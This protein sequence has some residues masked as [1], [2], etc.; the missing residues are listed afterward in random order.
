MATSAASVGEGAGDAPAPSARE[1][2]R[3]DIRIVEVVVA[4][5]RHLVEADRSP[6]SMSPFLRLT[7]CGGP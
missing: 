1:E 2:G 3:G 7:T 4:H 6:A 5:L